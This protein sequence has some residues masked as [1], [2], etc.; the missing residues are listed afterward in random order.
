VDSYGAFASLIFPALSSLRAHEVYIR[1]G[2]EGYRHYLPLTPASQYPPASACEDISSMIFFEASGAEFIPSGDSAPRSHDFYAV[3]MDSFPFAS[4]RFDEQQYG[5]CANHNP[6]SEW[7]Q[8]NPFPAPGTSR[9]APEAVGT[10]R[11]PPS[12]SPVPPEGVRQLPGTV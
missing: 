7:G 4:A 8:L 9:R 2:L 10:V 12:P 5:H 3:E 1:H 11:R 6:K